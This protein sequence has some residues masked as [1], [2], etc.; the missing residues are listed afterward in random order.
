MKEEVGRDM[1]LTDGE[2]KIVLNCGLDSFINHIALFCAER[3]LQFG[4]SQNVGYSPF[5]LTSVWFAFII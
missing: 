2:N 4:P 3:R 1:S 5:L